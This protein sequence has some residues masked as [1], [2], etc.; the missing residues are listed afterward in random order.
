MKPL[1][2]SFETLACCLA[3]VACSGSA[4]GSGSPMSEPFTQ[5]ST[6]VPTIYTAKLE[7]LNKNYVAGGLQMGQ[8]IVTVENDSVSIRL[9]G[10]TLAPNMIHLAHIQHGDR[11]PDTMGNDANHDGVL[12]VVEGIPAYGLIL[13]NFGANV[14]SLAESLEGGAPVTDDK[15]ALTYDGSGLLSSMTADLHERPEMDPATGIG[16]LAENEDLKFENTVVV[17]HGI[18]DSVALPPTAMGLK[19]MSAQATLPILC[20]R[21]QITVTPAPAAAE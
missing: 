2:L 1:L 4:P 21:L 18:P 3:L 6:T 19:D 5:R 16:K 20:G 8:A 13:V 9:I 12:D 11:C 17:V 10:A 14:S 15:G 7:P